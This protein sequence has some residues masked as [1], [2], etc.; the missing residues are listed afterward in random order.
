MFVEVELED[1]IQ[2]APRDLEGNEKRAVEQQLNEYYTGKYVPDVGICVT[3]KSVNK[4]LSRFIYQ[5]DATIHY[6]TQFTM[7]VFRPF[8][9]EV[10]Q[11]QIVNQN[12]LGIQV[13]LGFFN[14]VFIP[15]RAL[16]E[17]S[18][19]GEDNVWMWS[20]EGQEFFFDKG[21]QVKVRVTDI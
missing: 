18:I 12:N 13:A 17:G 16:P 2:V 15:A 21:E 14:D 1:E 10:I 5:Q 6:K 3:V 8:R 20:Y 4:I 9:N 7:C 19:F 11:G